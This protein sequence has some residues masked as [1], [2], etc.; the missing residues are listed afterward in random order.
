MPDS[1][2]GTVCGICKRKRKRTR[3]QSIS[4]LDPQRLGFQRIP[5]VYFGRQYFRL[6]TD[7]ST[8]QLVCKSSVLIFLLLLIHNVRGY[9]LCLLIEL[10]TGIQI[11]SRCHHVGF[12]A[13]GP[14]RRSDAI[15]K[16]FYR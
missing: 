12:A 16:P 6:S 13:T 4:L 7:L 1:G 3:R 14:I 5:R 15:Y 11:A 10:N 8:P 9:L 2:L